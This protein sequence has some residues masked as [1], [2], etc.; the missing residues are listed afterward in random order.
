MKRR[1][2]PTFTVAPGSPPITSE[3]VRQALDDE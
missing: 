2:F 3:T 1:G